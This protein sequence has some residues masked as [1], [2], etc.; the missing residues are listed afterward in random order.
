MGSRIER[1]S[2]YYQWRCRELWHRPTTAKH[3]DVPN[4]PPGPP[5]IDVTQEDGP[6]TEL[7]Q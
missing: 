3:S 2:D 7:R 1:T 6:S 5:N 4:K